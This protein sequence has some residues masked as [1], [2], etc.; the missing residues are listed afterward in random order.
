MVAICGGEP[1]AAEIQWEAREF[2]GASDALRGGLGF[3]HD[4]RE[5]TGGEAPG[6]R[7][8]CGAVT[9]SPFSGRR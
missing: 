7:N 1:A 8:I 4:G 5:T 6:R 3:Q 2:P 9:C